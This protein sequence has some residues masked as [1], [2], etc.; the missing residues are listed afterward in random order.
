MLTLPRRLFL[1]HKPRNGFLLLDLPRVWNE[2]DWPVVHC[3]VLLILFEGESAVFAFLQSSN[4]PFRHDET[5][6]TITSPAFSAPSDPPILVPWTWRGWDFSRDPW[7]GSPW[8]VSPDTAVKLLVRNRCGK[9][10]K[11]WSMHCACCCISHEQSQPHENWLGATLLYVNPGTYTHLCKPVK[12]HTTH[13]DQLCGRLGHSVEVGRI[14][15]Y[16]KALH[17]SSQGVLEGAAPHKDVRL[18]LFPILKSSPT[19][20][21]SDW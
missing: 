7:L 2:T 15:K 21:V 20:G 10:W 13:K 3:I 4:L 18:V 5:G 12:W 9:Q 8:L 16:S 6:S 14:T 19:W 1:L 17:G 11:K